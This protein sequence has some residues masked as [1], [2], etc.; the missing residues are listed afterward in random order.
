D[1]NSHVGLGAK[2]SKEVASAIRGVIILAKLPI[3]PVWRGYQGYKIDK[4]HT[5]P[6]KVTGH[7][8]SV[9]VHLIPA[10]RST[11]IVSAPVTKKLL[12]LAS[13]DDC[14]TSGRGF[15][16]TLDTFAKAIFDTISKTYSYLSP[17]LWK[18]TMF[19][20]FPYQEF[21]DQLVKTYTRASVQRTQA[22]SE[23]TI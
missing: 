10:C 19:M 22:P 13:I 23:A 15:T 6:C 21:T 16:A 1:Y 11:G 20:K 7:C 2:C 12:L 17:N 14:Y 3:V 5:V 8:G 4:L 18:E 9:L